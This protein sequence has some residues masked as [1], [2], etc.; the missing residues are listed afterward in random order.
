MLKITALKNITIAVNQVTPQAGDPIRRIPP[1]REQTVTVTMRTGEER[2]DISLVYGFVPLGVTIRHEYDIGQLE[3][4]PHPAN[5]GDVV[6]H[7]AK[8]RLEK[9][10]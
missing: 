8:I 5:I 4:I 7:E 6:E 10:S 9:L 2:Q 3:P 1:F